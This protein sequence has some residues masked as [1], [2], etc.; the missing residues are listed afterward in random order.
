MILYNCARCPAYCCSYAR[1]AVT[2]RDVERLAKHFDLPVETARRRFTKK[3]EEPGERVL[4]HAPDPHYGTAC[5][6]LDRETRR[7]TIYNSRPSI[8]R[9]YPGDGRCGYYDFLCFERRIQEDPEFVPTAYNV[10]D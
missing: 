10:P 1:I 2:E 4:R 3:G 5:R 8:C 9:S 7:C 6:F